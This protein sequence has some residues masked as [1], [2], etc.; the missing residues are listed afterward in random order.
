M[1]N[2]QLAA[3]IKMPDFDL[4]LG[5]KEILKAAITYFCRPTWK[6]AVA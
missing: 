4:R 5:G 6:L 1:E 3:K 2:C